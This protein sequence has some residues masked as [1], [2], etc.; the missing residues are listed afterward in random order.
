MNNDCRHETEVAL[1]K[2]QVP[3]SNSQRW[4]KGINDQDG[5]FPLQNLQNGKYLAA[6]SNETTLIIGNYVLLS[7]F[8]LTTSF[9]CSLLTL[10]LTRH[11][12]YTLW[13]YICCHHNSKR[14]EARLSHL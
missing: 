2:K 14:E 1:E 10:L 6:E 4:S 8:V 7:K 11:F 13:C 12:Y 3:V 9:T 5:Y